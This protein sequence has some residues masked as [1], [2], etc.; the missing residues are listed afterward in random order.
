MCTGQQFFF[1]KK[2]FVLLFSNFLVLHIVLNEN[3]TAIFSSS[4]KQLFCSYLHYGL[5]AARAEILKAVGDSSNP[6]ILAGFH[7]I[8]KSPLLSA[9]Y[10]HSVSATDHW[11]LHLMDVF[12][13]SLQ[14][15]VAFYYCKVA[16]G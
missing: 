9:F 10:I 12:E 2:S 6:C 11:T 1:F 15:F 5:L 16:S 14:C 8:V 13:I 3:P 4:L 7:G